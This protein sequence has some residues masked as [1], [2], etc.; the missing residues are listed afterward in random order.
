MVFI[1]H[2]MSL[3]SAGCDLTQLCNWQW[4]KKVRLKVAPG[5]KA[6]IVIKGV[7]CSAGMS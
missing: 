7:L 6:E 5:T 2:M 1:L 3:G 4:A